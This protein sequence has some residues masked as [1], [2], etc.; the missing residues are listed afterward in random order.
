MD[1]C[2][3][4]VSYS[5]EYSS[6]LV[7]C[8]PGMDTCQTMVSYS[9]EL[10]ESVILDARRMNTALHLRCRAVFMRRT[11]RSIRCSREN[12]ISRYVFLLHIFITIFGMSLLPVGVCDIE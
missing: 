7:D 10:F 11:S 3:T 9:G 2:Q 5:G 1:T 8:G 12:P 6:N 4:M